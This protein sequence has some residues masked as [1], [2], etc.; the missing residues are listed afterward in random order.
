MGRARDISK[1]FSTNTA[2]AT[3]SEISAFNYLTQASASTVY[4]TKA[5]TGLTL[6]TPASIANTGGTASIG[7]NGTI[8]LSG[9]SNISLND[10]F[11]ATYENYRIV[12]TLAGS[13]TFNLLY[14]F[15]VG[16]SDN[17][18]ANYTYSFGRA[19]STD[20]QTTFSG[21]S[22]TSAQIGVVAQTT[23]AKMPFSFDIYQPFAS[24]YSCGL[25][26]QQDN[27]NAAQNIGGWYF[28][29]NTSFTGFS[30]I[31]STGTMSGEVSIYG[32]N[33]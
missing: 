29:G 20:W 9:V 4:Q 25:G 33:K 6:L 5:T 22:Q 15:R 14:R 23:N 19:R 1:V 13:G 2:L 28:V 31:T 26:F 18:T 32:Y 12:G 3:D 16:G 11:N 24:F 27:S 10:V 17:S 30:F 21:A 8:T 7:T